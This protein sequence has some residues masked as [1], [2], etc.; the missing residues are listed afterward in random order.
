MNFNAED[1]MIRGVEREIRERETR[2]SELQSTMRETVGQNCITHFIALTAIAEGTGERLELQFCGR[3]TFYSILIVSVAFVL[4]FWMTMT[5]YLC[6]CNFQDYY[7]EKLEA[8]K[9]TRPGPVHFHAKERLAP[10]LYQ[11]P[12]LLWWQCAFRRCLLSPLSSR[13]RSIVY[14]SH[15]LRMFLAISGR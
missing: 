11:C 12:C 13:T 2:I 14:V 6:C 5:K 7:V 15:V 9:R 1:L 4:L 8:L 10:R 3:Y